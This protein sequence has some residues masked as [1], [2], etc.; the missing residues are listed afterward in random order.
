MMGPCAKVVVKCELVLKDGR[1]FRGENA[2]H[3]PQAVCPR[4]PGEDYEK[5]HT[6]CQQPR[7]AETDA[8][9]KAHVIAGKKALRGATIYVD[10]DRI[11]DECQW[12]IDDLEITAVI[13]GRPTTPAT[14]A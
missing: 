3:S 14:T 7:H 13:R 8:I 5:C 12:H 1:T 4:L 10:Y 6:I 9:M 2:C 11:C